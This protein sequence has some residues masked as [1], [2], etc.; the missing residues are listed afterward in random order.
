[1]PA[2]SQDSKNY[3]HFLSLLKT[4]HDFPGFADL[5][6]REEQLLNMLGTVW[7]TDKKITVV[8]AMDIS[9][10]SSSTTV[11]RRLKSLRKKGFIKLLNDEIDGRIKYVMPT[12]LAFQYFAQ[13]GQCMKVAMAN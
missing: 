3:L 11:H 10:N 13:I 2:N 1:M 12:D 8:H 7:R 9:I 4:A 5:E 6:I